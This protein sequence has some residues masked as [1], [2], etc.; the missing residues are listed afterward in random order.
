MRQQRDER[1]RERAY[2]IWEAAGRPNGKS[3]EHWTQAEQEVEGQTS[4]DDV[5]IADEAG[6]NVEQEIPPKEEPGEP[7]IQRAQIDKK[8]LHRSSGRKGR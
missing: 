4:T 3:I 6:F 5:A 2:Q 8:V 7:S 1:I